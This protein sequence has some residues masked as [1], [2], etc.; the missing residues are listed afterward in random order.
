MI[1]YGALALN[2]PFD[3]AYL[4]ERKL[5]KGLRVLVPFGKG[6]NLST[7]FII[8][9]PEDIQGTL[10]DYNAAS[11]IK[12]KAIS[13]VLDDE[14]ILNDELLGLA[15]KASDY[16][17]CPLISMLKT[18]LPPSLQPDKKS[19]KSP[20]IPYEDICYISP[21]AALS[22]FSFDSYEKKVLARFSKPG[23]II[24][25][26]AFSSKITLE[27]LIAKGVI[28]QEKRRKD[29]DLGISKIDVVS[30]ELNQEQ[31][32][33]YEEI[34]SG[35]DQKY[36]LQGV[37]GS[38]KTE[39]YI[40]LIS[41]YLSKGFG[42][43]VLVPEISLTDRMITLF[44]SLFGEKAALLHSG[45]SAG[46]KYQEYLRIALGEANLVVGARSAIFAPVKNLGLI[47]LDEEHVESYKQDT[48]PFYDAR[49]IAVMR[50]QGHEERKLVF[51]SATP[52]LDIR[53]RADRGMYKLVKMEKRYN[54]VL[55]PSSDIVDLSD[56]HN[57][58]YHSTLISIPLRKAIEEALN[59]RKQVILFLNR[60][61]FS[62]MYICRK[63]Q[64][65]VKCPNCDVPLTYHKKDGKLSCHHCDYE[66]AASNLVC[67]HCGGKDFEYI[68]YGTERAANEVQA[69]FPQAK[70]VRFDADTTRNKGEYHKIITAFA[71]HEYDIMIGTQLVA[72]GHDFPDVGLAAALLA[73]QS[74]S[75]PTYKA[76]E[77]TFDLL[78]QLSGRA[79]RKDE[80]GLSLIQTYSPANPVIL[81]AQK[82]DYESFYKYEM[83]NR[84]QRQ[85]PPY[86]FLADISISG[87]KLEAVADAAR[88]AKNFLTVKLVMAGR[89]CN[90]YGP[91]DPFISK[92]GNRYY[93]ALMIKYKIASDVHG[94]LMELQDMFLRQGDIKISIDI[95]PSSDI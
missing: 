4:G 2:R 51:G 25:R 49:K 79:G 76:D 29:K 24:P 19:L 65:P 94:V 58:D 60:R 85:Y 5:V 89:K 47:I 74:L 45:L 69:L 6:A 9:D 30:H 84:C 17:L 62:P 64:K 87:T 21:K 10:E 27:K 41:S 1:E 32:A 88:K 66:I 35:R 3:Y 50:V 73:D 92:K 78:T 16:Y 46:Q 59:N 48:S 56:Y 38:G 8:E 75:F 15:K 11:K 12:M 57:I 80:Q 20:K 86:V 77:D 22:A 13:S 39:V 31:E 54:G 18:M 70:I 67:P 28:C 81:L 42:C 61:G 93:K 52:S 83:A 91:S 55:L 82:Q 71:S 43:L 14:P 40:K 37:T 53:A 26:T 23:E 36:L 34:L 68:G 44:K 95:D 7:G 90:V 72:K 33:A 63:C